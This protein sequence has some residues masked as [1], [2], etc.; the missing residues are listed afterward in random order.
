[1]SKHGV[2]TAIENHDFNADT[3]ED[4]DNCTEDISII[5][6][7]LLNDK[8]EIVKALCGDVKAKL[9]MLTD[10]ITNGYLAGFAVGI[11]HTYKDL[12]NGDCQVA[13]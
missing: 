4:C 7:Q 9:D 13:S 10:M 3:D 1:M 11:Q 8:P 12:I 2:S 6:I 5:V